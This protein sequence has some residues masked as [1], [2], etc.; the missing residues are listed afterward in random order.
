MAIQH[1]TQSTFNAS[2]SNPCLFQ[3]TPRH[4]FIIYS[5]STDCS[6]NKHTH[7]T[8]LIM[9]PWPTLNA[10]KGHTFLFQH[11][12]TPE[13]GLI[14]TFTEMWTQGSTQW[15]Q[16]QKTQ[17]T[18]LE[19][20][21]NTNLLCVGGNTLRFDVR[22]IVFTKVTLQH[23]F[24]NTYVSMLHIF[25]NIKEGLGHHKDILSEGRW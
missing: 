11:H 13:D 22:S 16:Y 21:K 10:L 2:T 20:K 14:K 1:W 9:Q 23:W 17:R 6:I 4:P 18:V 15:V 7:K 19:M 5:S 3:T 25:L 12:R 24:V 8:N